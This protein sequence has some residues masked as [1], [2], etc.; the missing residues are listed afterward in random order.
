[1]TKKKSVA[2][3]IVNKNTRKKSLKVLAD[4]CPDNVC[5]IDKKKKKNNNTKK[6][7]CLSE[8]QNVWNKFLNF[9]F[10]SRKK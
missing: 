8:S 4:E 3:K 7:C 9:V 2:K 10:P 6:N 1:M 5:P